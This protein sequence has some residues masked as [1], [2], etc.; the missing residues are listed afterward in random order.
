MSIVLILNPNGGEGNSPPL[1][2]VG[3][4]L[5]PAPYLAD[6]VGLDDA[7]FPIDTDWDEINTAEID[8]GLIDEAMLV[9]PTPSDVCRR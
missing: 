5:P 3:G 9:I 1:D 2:L 6:A 7:S 8:F 4:Q